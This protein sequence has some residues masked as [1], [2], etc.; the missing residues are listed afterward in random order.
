M[1]A[2]TAL[3]AA[4][5]GAQS[6]PAR[7]RQSSPAP[8]PQVEIEDPPTAEVLAAITRRGRVIAEADAAAWLGSGAMTSLELPHDS[9]R[10]LIPRRTSRGWEV[11]CGTLS[12]D[13]KAYLMSQLATPG[14][15]ADHWASSLFEPA[16][17]DS[18]YFARAARAIEASLSMFRRAAPRAYIALALPADDGPTWFVYVYPAPSQQG[19]WPRGGD[20]RFQVSA[21]GRIVTQSRR[22]HETITEYSVRTARSATTK[23]AD[24]HPAVSG[25]APEDTDVFHVIQRRPAIPELMTAGRF[26]YRIDVDGTIRLIGTIPTPP[27]NAH[28]RSR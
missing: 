19:V 3:L 7:A 27:N 20:M 6:K 17:P 16:R 15:Y 12:A 11:A 24:A 22:L 23:A 14:I 5:L 9:I 1:I 13:E 28:D 10:R 18:G 21:D 4:H 25:N 26:Q 8:R 2:L